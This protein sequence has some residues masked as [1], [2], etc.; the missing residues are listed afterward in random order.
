LISL[1]LTKYLLNKYNVKYDIP[2]HNRY[3]RQVALHTK[4]SGVKENVKN[5]LSDLQSLFTTIR[6]K[7]FNDENADKRSNFHE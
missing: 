6:T 5:A 2:I 4:L 3:D 7:I 1:E